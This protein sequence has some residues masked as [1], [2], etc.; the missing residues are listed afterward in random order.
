MLKIHINGFHSKLKKWMDRFNGVATKY[1]ANYMYW[2]KWLQ[3]FDTEKN[4]IK[5]K[6]LLVQ[7]HTWHINKILKDFRFREVVIYVYV[8]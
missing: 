3:I 6:H 4:T 5:S 8:M 2:F 7:S 1:P